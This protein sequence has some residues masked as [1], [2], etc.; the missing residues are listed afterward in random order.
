M[1]RAAGASGRPFVHLNF[2]LDGEGRMAA[3]D[4][5]QISI[6]CQKDW[7][8]MHDLR[9]R[10]DAVAVG[11]TTWINDRPRLTA[12]QERLGYEPR[13]QPARVIFAGRR[14]LEVN[15]S[16]QT[17]LIGERPPPANGR[18][19]AGSVVFI[20]A[21]GHDLAAPLGALHTAGLRTLL[22]E[23]GITLLRSFLE[24][25]LFDQLDVYVR[26]GS[27]ETA[28][29]LAVRVLR[30]LPPTL[31][32]RPLGAGLLLSHARADFKKTSL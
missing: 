10:Y 4:G 17:F 13:R 12:R 16:R 7:R 14:A 27:V 28:R 5:S 29:D 8:R 18:D 23:G 6:S 26:A 19:E 21:T 15:G 32:E 24:Q 31:V 22:V 30:E 20:P 3:L 11:A 2:A 25:E 1:Y 9:E